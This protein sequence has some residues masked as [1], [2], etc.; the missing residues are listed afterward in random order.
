MLAVLA[1]VI[2]IVV[3]VAA[4]DGAQAHKEK[5]CCVAPHDDSMIVLL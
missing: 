5:G 4:L 2:V 3:G 1:I